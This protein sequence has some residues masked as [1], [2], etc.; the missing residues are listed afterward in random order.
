[1]CPELNTWLILWLVLLAFAAGLALALER[2]PPRPPS[3]AVEVLQ[4]HCQR[5]MVFDEVQQALVPG[6]VCVPEAE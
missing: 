3:K 1:M 2:D 4:D 5:G 6:I